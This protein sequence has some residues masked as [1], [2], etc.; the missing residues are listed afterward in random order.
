MDQW[1]RP[2]FARTRTPVQSALSNQS[3]EPPETEDTMKSIRPSSRVSSYIGFR[4]SSANLHAPAGDTFTFQHVNIPENVYH[5]PSGSQMAETLKV[6][7]M[8]R[9]LME[10]IPVEYNTCILHVLEAYNDLQEMLA[11]KEGEIEEIK[12]RH[13][14]DIREFDSMAEQW[15]AKERDYQKEIKNLEV[16]L[17]KTE[18]GMENVTMARS[19]SVVHGT[20][21]AADVFE[22]GMEKIKQNFAR[23][24]SG[25]DSSTTTIDW[26]IDHL[27]QI[28]SSCPLETL[29]QAS[30]LSQQQADI[31]HEGTVKS[32]HRENSSVQDTESFYSAVDSQSTRL[33]SVQ[34]DALERQHATEELG[35]VFDSSSE[36]DDTSS[37][38]AFTEGQAPTPNRTP[39][40]SSI[41]NSNK[42]KPLPDIPTKH[43]EMDPFFSGEARNVQPWVE[44]QDD[45]QASSSAESRKEF[46]FKTGD[47]TPSVL[48]KPSKV[49]LRKINPDSVPASR[50][51]Y[52]MNSED[53][54]V[55]LPRHPIADANSQF[56]AKSKT[57]NVMSKPT[58]STSPGKET[59]ATG[60]RQQLGMGRGMGKGMERGDSNSSIVTAVRDNS[61]R[62][63]KGRPA[64]EDAGAKGNGSG[65]KQKQSQG[66]AVMAAVRAIAASNKSATA[67]DRIQAHANESDRKEVDRREGVP[68]SPERSPT[69]SQVGGGRE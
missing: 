4:S 36:S 34:L 42:E 44:P 57:R 22:D 65:G 60:L 11:V 37:R 53:E 64:R 66:T 33:T 46:S 27:Q 35:V 61:G 9:N 16:L 38:S 31:N 24:S 3:D 55:S 68:F 13:T 32:R 28:T 62:S 23:Y 63:D 69:G 51:S 18:G 30:E 52:V 39:K 29:T 8:T 25:R 43:Q 15:K 67:N 56:E 20:R 5:K 12:G 58:V 41:R 26:N 54:F 45:G 40:I 49:V 19:K 47:D 48:H 7:M 1:L 6:I 21:R 2:V 59:Y 10:S 50:L 17:S 14:K